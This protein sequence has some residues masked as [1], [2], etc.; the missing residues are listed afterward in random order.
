MQINSESAMKVVEEY[1]EKVNELLKKS[2]KD[3]LDEKL[4]LDTTIQNFIRTTFV[5]GESKLKD[6]RSSVHFYIGVVGYEETEQEKQ[7]DYISRLKTIKNHLV[8]F[9]EEL[10][11]K[12]ATHEKSSKFDKIENETQIRDAEA[13]RRASVVEGKLWGAVIELL[14]VQRNELKKK[15]ELTQ[16]IIDIKKEI[17]DLKSIFLKLAENISQEKD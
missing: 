15:D 4:E 16:E 7:D 14:D 11:L 6:Y 9:R 8:A 10:K 12:A 17:K 13:R 2:Y 5:D 3:G 1:I